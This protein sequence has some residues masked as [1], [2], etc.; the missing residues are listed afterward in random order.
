MIKNSLEYHNYMT[1]NTDLCPELNYNAIFSIDYVKFTVFDH[2]QN[3]SSINAIFINNFKYVGTFKDTNTKMIFKRFE[4]ICNN[5]KTFINL[6]KCPPKCDFKGSII[7]VE[8]PNLSITKHFDNMFP[9]K[10]VSQVEYTLDMKTKERDK[11]FNFIKYSILLKWN[12]NILGNK[13]KTTHYLNNIRKTKGCGA[14]VYEKLND[15]VR[16]ESIFK[17][18]TIK[19]LNIR[20]LSD[21]FS[22]TPTVAFERITF[23]Y[24]DFHRYIK[25]HIL[26]I[27]KRFPLTDKERNLITQNITPSSSKFIIELENDGLNNIRSIFP[28][29]DLRSILLTHPFDE[30]FKAT[31]AAGKFC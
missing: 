8:H 6:Y 20:K 14:R 10:K 15:I 27:T 9:T 5:Y 24:I 13:Y 23:K 30:I 26:N 1:R 22:I 21:I 11:L 17:R 7:K 31:L 28:K 16:V 18:R 2:I 12:L 3:F 19:Q 29:S 25:K 4:I